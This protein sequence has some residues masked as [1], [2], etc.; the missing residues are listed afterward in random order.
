MRLPRKIL[1]HALCLGLLWSAVAY[2]GAEPKRVTVS[3]PTLQTLNFSVPQ[4]QRKSPV[5]VLS[6]KR[7][8][9]PGFMVPLA[10]DLDVVTEFLLVPYAALGS[11]CRHPRQTRLSMSRWTRIPRFR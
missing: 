4:S 2:F 10:D 11:M 1:R 5:L 8:S 9:I 6:S 3:W 7:V